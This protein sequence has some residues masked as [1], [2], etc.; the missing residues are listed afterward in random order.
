MI[1]IIKLIKAAKLL[2]KIIIL[3]NKIKKYVNEIPLKVIMLDVLKMIINELIKMIF[4]KH[5]G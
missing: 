5:Q 1:R 3:K 2:T 4:E